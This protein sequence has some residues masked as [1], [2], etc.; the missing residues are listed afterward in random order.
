[1]SIQ[2]YKRQLLSSGNIVQELHYGPF[3]TSWWGFIKTKTAQNKQICI[4]IRVNMRI[5]FELNQ[6]ELIIRVVDNNLKPGY[7]CESD[8]EAMIYSTSSAAINETYKK[9]FDAKTRFSGPNVLGFD[10]EVIVKQLQ[11]EVL[12]F[13]FQIIIQNI[14]IFVTALSSSDQAEWNFAGPG[15]H[16]SFF[17]KYRRQCSLIC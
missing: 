6:E 8:T 4:P 16:S 13:S 11:A 10:D 12:F 15:Y 1:M 7:V 2:N 17:Y 5:K 3:A 9:I 14:T